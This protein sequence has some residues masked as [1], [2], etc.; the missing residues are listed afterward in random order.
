[1]ILLHIECLPLGL[2]LSKGMCPFC[3]LTSVWRF[4]LWLWDQKPTHLFCSANQTWLQSQVVES[5]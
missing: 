2:Y 3:T 1:M 4:Y 5:L